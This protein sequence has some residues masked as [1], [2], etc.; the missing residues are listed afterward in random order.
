MSEPTVTTPRKFSRERQV[1]SRYSF[2]RATLWRLVKDR[3][4]PQPIKIGPKTTVW[5]EAELDAYDEA[6]LAS[7]PSAI[8]PAVM[9]PRQRG[10]ATRRRARP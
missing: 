3:K 6:L 4:F 8:S 2:S 10:G 9:P 5:V 1:T 7:R